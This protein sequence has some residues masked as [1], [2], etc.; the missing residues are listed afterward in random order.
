[1]FAY[2]N[3]IFTISDGYK[4]VDADVLTTDLSGSDAENINFRKYDFAGYHRTDPKLLL[5]GSCLDTYIGGELYCADGYDGVGRQLRGVS[6]VEQAYH[7]EEVLLEQSGHQCILLRRTRTGARCACFL[8]TLEHPDHRCPNCF[9]PGT[10]V[11]T[12]CGLKPIED[13]NVGERVLSSD[14]KY[15]TVT[16]TFENQY[17]GYLQEILSSISTSPILTTAEHPFLVMRGAHNVKRGCGPKC[18]KYINDGNGVFSQPYD[19]RQLPS[20]NWHARLT[21]DGKR[22]VL[23]S[24]ESKE[25]A[26]EEIDKYKEENFDAGHELVWD[27]AKNISDGDWLVSKHYMG[28]HDIKSIEV[29]KQFRKNTKLGTER[30]GPNIFFV[31]REFLWVIGMYI[32]EGSASKRSINFALHRKEEKYRDRLVDFFRSNGYNPCVRKSSENG[33]VV[34]INSTTLSNWFP[35][36]IGK[37]CYN[38]HIPNELMALPSSKLMALVSGINDGD[39]TKNL[40]ENEISQTSEILTMQL[41]E[42]LHRAGEKPQVRTSQAKALTPIGNKRKKCY[43]VNWQKDSCKNINRKGR[44]KFKNELLTKVRRADK[45]WYSGKV[46]NL[47]VEGDHTYVVQNIV[48][49][50]CTGTGFVVGYEQYFNPRRS[51]GRILVRFEPAPDDLKLDVAGLE[52]ELIVPCWTLVAPT[53]KDRD[54]LRRYNQDGSREFAYEILHVTRNKLFYGFDGVQKF[55][56]Q[57]IRKTDPV[58]QVSTIDSTANIPETVTTSI[59]LMRGANNAVTPH[60]HEIKINENVIILSQINQTTSVSAGHSHTVKEGVVLSSFG[61]IHTIILP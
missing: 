28:V 45:K 13:I 10:V 11:N 46:Y 50:N 7:R 58:Y 23:G 5:A 37:R 16:R 2:P 36:W 59:G 39:G 61:H 54:V 38:K 1:M 43:I 44:W 47:E 4:T 55:T 22:V 31:D 49:H 35:N 8:P 6:I 24:Y 34:E 25:R 29:P 51:D 30:L 26:I 41:V 32:A 52:S 20:R 17:D 3:E 27:D 33:I 12:S 60:T 53:V 18:N 15:H 57:R 19:V 56:A 42:V 9:V 48:V 21:F 40:R 14:G